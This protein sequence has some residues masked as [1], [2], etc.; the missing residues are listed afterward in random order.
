MKGQKTRIDLTPL[1]QTQARMKGEPVDS[2]CGPYTK[3][4]SSLSYFWTRFLDP[5]WTM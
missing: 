4:N 5:P 3:G 1:S 2:P